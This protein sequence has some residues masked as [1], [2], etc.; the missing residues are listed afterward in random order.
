[1]TNDNISTHKSMD[2]QEESTVLTSELLAKYEE[3]LSS[4]YEITNGLTKT[5]QRIQQDMLTLDAPIDRINK[6]LMLMSVF[7]SM[8]DD[9][10]DCFDKWLTSINRIV[11]NVLS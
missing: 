7:L 11:N 2:I 6:D 4:I 8:N 1:M 10:T 9:L 5:Y 3:I